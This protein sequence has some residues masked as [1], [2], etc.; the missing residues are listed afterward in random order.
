MSPAELWLVA[1]HCLWTSP[2]FFAIVGRAKSRGSDRD[3]TIKAIS[4]GDEHGA[5]DHQTSELGG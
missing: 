5:V 3:E 1:T 2:A 4:R